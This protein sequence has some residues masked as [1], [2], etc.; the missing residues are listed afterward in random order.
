MKDRRLLTERLNHLLG[1]TMCCIF[2]LCTYTASGITLPAHDSIAPTTLVGFD[3]MDG[4]VKGVE[5]EQEEA[6]IKEN[7]T[8]NLNQT[9]IGFF[10]ITLVDF[11]QEAVRVAIYD[12][13]TEDMLYA[14]NLEPDA[15][16]YTTA[17][18]TV[19]LD[20]GEYYVVVEGDTRIVPKTLTIE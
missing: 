6:S 9:T 7:V 4:N 20:A 5:A 3:F 13:E 12:V 15:E 19:P 11:A 8:L 14:I 1:L 2:V 10:T 18:L 16:L 17:L